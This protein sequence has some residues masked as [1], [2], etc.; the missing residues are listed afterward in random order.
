MD[1]LCQVRIASAIPK[2]CDCLSW[3]LGGSPTKR[4][5]IRNDPYRG[6]SAAGLLTGRRRGRPHGCQS[7]LCV[8]LAI[9]KTAQTRLNSTPVRS[10][11]SGRGF[12]AWE[13]PTERGLYTCAGSG[14][15]FPVPRWRPQSDKLPQHGRFGRGSVTKET[16]PSC[17]W[18]H[19]LYGPWRLRRLDFSCTHWI[20]APC[21]RAVGLLLGGDNPAQ[22]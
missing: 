1:L 2:V 12:S 18:V 3:G 16:R 15:R 13:P 7:S 10:G 8:F 5:H 6:M 22:K 17:R 4:N 9:V 19:F 11:P 20:P 21:C 14:E